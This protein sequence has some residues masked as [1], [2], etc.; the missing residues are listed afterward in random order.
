MNFTI[1]SQKFAEAWLKL[2]ILSLAIA[3]GFSIFLVILRSPVNQILP[4]GLFKQALIVHVNLSVL[5]WI[6]SVII[7]EF[8]DY[9]SSK[10]YLLAQIATISGFASVVAITLS[11]FIPGS[12]GLLCNYVPVL[13]NL[14][15]FIALSLLFTIVLIMSIIFILSVN[16]R[17]LKSFRT[18]TELWANY[19]IAISILVASIGFIL[20]AKYMN[21]YL[22]NHKLDI[23]DF[24]EMSFWGGG[25]L[26]QFTFLQIMC[27]AWF[28][29]TKSLIGSKIKEIQPLISYLFLANLVFQIFGLS[30]YKFDIMD[31]SHHLFFTWHMKY[32]AGIIPIIFSLI[33]LYSVF[34]FASKSDFKVVF[35]L[36][37]I[38]LFVLGGVV[39]LNIKGNDVTV[40]AHYHGSIVGVTL[41]LMGLVLLKIEQYKLGNIDNKLA[42]IQPVCYT[43]GQFLHIMGLAWSGG[44]GVLRKNPDVMLSKSAKIAMSLMGGGGLVAIV[45]GFL[46]IY[47]CYKA[48]YHNEAQAI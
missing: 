22:E 31:P 24:Y 29:L 10:F 37:S 6:I 27:L 3:G 42:C 23:E 15:F 5:F 1:K 11:A 16:L 43:A 25:H 8:L 13:Q 33:I 19:N 17:E 35:L 38:S 18:E 9:I 30:G 45:G 21:N 20:S 14:P 26:L 39:S 28:R 32:F 44:Y 47:V 36:C 2:S 7:A 46:F 41:G 4:H 34:K 48:L 40:P 12:L